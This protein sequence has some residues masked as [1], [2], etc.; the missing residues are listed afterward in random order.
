MKNRK[1]VDVIDASRGIRK[2]ESKKTLMHTKYA[3]FFKHYT[4]MVIILL[5][6]DGEEHNYLVRLNPYDKKYFEQK[7]DDVGWR[8]FGDSINK[9]NDG[10]LKMIVDSHYYM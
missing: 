1:I 3:G 10:R 7:I 8:V 5:D 6:Y 2:T 9:L 4:H